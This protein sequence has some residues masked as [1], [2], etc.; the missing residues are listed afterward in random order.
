MKN[1]QK[2]LEKFKNH[3]KKQMIS[4]VPLGAFLSGGIDSSQ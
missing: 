3:L 2:D 4:D 1:I